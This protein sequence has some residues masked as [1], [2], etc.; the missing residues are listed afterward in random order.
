MIFISGLCLCL[1]LGR[2]GRGNRVRTRG[3]RELP[4]GSSVDA[5]LR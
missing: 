3:S 5:G 1:W 4:H 2:E